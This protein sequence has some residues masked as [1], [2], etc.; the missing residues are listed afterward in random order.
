MGK[1]K[2]EIFLGPMACACSG[3][4]SPAKV[5]KI[6]RALALKRSLERDSGDSFSVKAWDLGDDSDY[7]EGLMV[8]RE[9]LRNAGRS[10]L[11]ERLAF[12]LNDATPSVAVNGKL[13]WIRDCPE[14][15]DFL[16]QFETAADGEAS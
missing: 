8:L 5:E 16:K 10:E 3:M 9:Y 15:D 12:A 7:E 13:I 11:S 6:N 1:S 2:V 14:A 4:P